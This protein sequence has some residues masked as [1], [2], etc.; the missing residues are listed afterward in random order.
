M[1]EDEEKVTT[2]TAIK[3]IDKS[4]NLLKGTIETNTVFN[5]D[6]LT[7]LVIAACLLTGLVIW[8]VLKYRCK[9]NIGP[10]PTQP[11]LPDV[12][13]SIHPSL[14]HPFPYMNYTAPPSYTSVTTNSPD[15]TPRPSAASF[16]V[17][18]PSTLEQVTCLPSTSCAKF[19]KQ[20]I[21]LPSSTSESEDSDTSEIVAAKKAAK[22]AKQKRKQLRKKEKKEKENI[23]PLAEN[24]IAPAVTPAT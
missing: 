21:V 3:K 9:M 13:P 10:T 24:T 16:P 15:P 2:T 11:A 8:K 12:I 22:A 20:T 14:P 5:S 19:K 6:Y 7:E 23:I 4:A 1:T 17:D 18:A